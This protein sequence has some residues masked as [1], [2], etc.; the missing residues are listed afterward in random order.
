M[1]G[2]RRRLPQSRLRGPLCLRFHSLIG[3]LDPLSRRRRN[4]KA[5]SEEAAKAT[6]KQVHLSNLRVSDSVPEISK[7]T[8]KKL[9]RQF[10][11]PILSGIP[12]IPHGTKAN[13]P[14]E[15]G[16]QREKQSPHG[17]KS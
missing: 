9:P 13:L 15:K 17:K 10:E 6:S 16:D 11:T 4:P 2:R 3:P 7:R 5:G 12:P 8:G 14:G 1:R